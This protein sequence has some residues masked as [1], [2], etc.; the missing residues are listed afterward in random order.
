MKLDQEGLTRKQRKNSLAI[1]CILSIKKRRKKNI[2]K[3][4]SHTT[5]N[6][7]YSFH[8]MEYQINNNF[9][10]LRLTIIVKK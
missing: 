5:Q 2:D 3:K 6:Q 9:F 1:D 10:T 4:T 7:T 8:K